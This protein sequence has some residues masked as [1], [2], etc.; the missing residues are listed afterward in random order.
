MS[1]ILLSGMDESTKRNCTAGIKRDASFIVLKTAAM[2][3]VNLVCGTCMPSKK[4]AV[5]IDQIGEKESEQK[6]G[7]RNLV[8][9]RMGG[10][11]QYD[12]SGLNSLKGK[13][14]G[15]MGGCYDCGGSH[16]QRDCPKGGKAK[17]GKVGKGQG[18]QKGK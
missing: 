15:P 2:A 6:Q 17:S 1:T 4:D 9:R 12:Q 8:G 14:N 18:A 7:K 13:G 11:S 5:D 16:F 3:F 10:E